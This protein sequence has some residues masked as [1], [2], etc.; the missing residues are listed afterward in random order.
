MIPSSGRPPSRGKVGYLVHGA[1]ELPPVDRPASSPGLDGAPA[2][3]RPVRGGSGPARGGRGRGVARRLATV[4]GPPGPLGGLAFSASGTGPGAPARRRSPQHVHHAPRAASL[5]GPAR[6]VRDQPR[7]RIPH[8]YRGRRPRV[9]GHGLEHGAGPAALTSSPGA[10]PSGGLAP[11]S[12]RRLPTVGRGARQRRRPPGLLP[13]VALPVDGGAPRPRGAVVRYIHHS[14]LRRAQRRA[15]GGGRLLL[16]G[17][18]RSAGDPS[19]TGGRRPLVG[20]QGAHRGVP[21]VPSR[22]R[23]LAAREPS[24]MVAG[25]ARRRRPA[26]PHAG[27]AAARKRRLAHPLRPN[28]GTWGPLWSRGGP[29]SD[30]AGARLLYVAHRLPLPLVDDGRASLA[31][32]GRAPGHARRHEPRPGVRVA[33]PGHS[34]PRRPGRARASLIARPDAGA[35]PGRGPPRRRGPRGSRRRDPTGQPQQR[36]DALPEPL[37]AVARASCR[38]RARAIRAGRSLGS[39]LPGG[40]G[41][42][43]PGHVARR[44]PPPHARALRHTH[45]PRRV[46]LAALPA[47]RG[48]VARGLRRADRA[49][50][51][52]GHRARGHRGMREGVAGRRRH[53]RRRLAAVVSAASRARGVLRPGCVLLRPH[54]EGAVLLFARPAPTGVRRAAALRLV[55]DGFARRGSRSLPGRDPVVEVVAPGPPGAP[56]RCLRD[57]VASAV[58]RPASIARSCSCG[59]RGRA[60]PL[61]SPCIPCRTTGPCS[62]IPFVP[63]CSTASFS[64]PPNRPRWSSPILRPCCSR[65]PLPRWCRAPGSLRL[66]A[67]DRGAEGKGWPPADVRRCGCD[68]ALRGPRRRS[69]A[70]ADFVRGVVQSPETPPP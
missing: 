50:R 33:R 45:A 24:R 56:R 40:H 25:A 5:P 70:M 52:P 28:A 39:C 53:C 41:R 29:A 69:A 62:S 31:R 8:S 42:G 15:A 6:R 65:S 32:P 51:R 22:G 34:P 20:G 12:H 38:S 36:G 66:L 44:L 57:G 18:P 55:L 9:R 64:T 37:R 17:T 1:D 30:G 63:R 61:P 16:L 47:G 48:P 2:R 49:L 21:C 10:A 26:K 13:F 46:A 14:G 60:P 67:P 4:L 35:S 68:D 27:R 7:P 11:A 19:G 23:G 59:S 58:S 54:H 3:S 43:L